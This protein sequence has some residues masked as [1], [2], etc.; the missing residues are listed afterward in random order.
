VESAA[1][2]RRYHAIDP[3]EKALGGRLVISFDDGTR[4]EDEIVLA[5]AHPLGSRPFAREY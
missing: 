4:L 5:D 1:W 3:G 2:S